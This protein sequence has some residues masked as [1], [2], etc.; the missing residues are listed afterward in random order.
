MKK[1]QKR[2]RWIRRLAGFC[3]LLLCWM[4]INQ[5]HATLSAQ[6][7]PQNWTHYVRI[8]A[9]GL[10][11]KDAASIVRDAQK[12]HIFGIEVDNDI[13]GRYESYLDP[14]E[15]LEAIRQVAEE[16]TTQGT[17]P[18]CT[19]RAPNASRPMPPNPRTRW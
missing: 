12:T 19:S 15:K 2:G 8:G 16:P 13:P 3:A 5:H 9:Y 18:S 17:T 10:E 1:E 4:L 7:A 6:E 14:R 11:R